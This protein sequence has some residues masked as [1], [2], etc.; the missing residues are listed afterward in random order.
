MN[1]RKL[2]NLAVLA[3]VVLSV[4]SCEKPY[5]GNHLVNETSPYLLQHAFNPVDWF[6]WGQEALNKA[7]EE[8]KL[9]VISVG[10]ASCH[11]CHVMEEESFEDSLVS[12]VMNESFISIKV[13]KE[14]RPDIDGIYMDACQLIR[15][16]SCGW[17]LNVIALPD[18]RPVFAGTYFEKEQWIQILETYK[19]RMEEE[20]DDL[21]DFANDLKREIV[22][23]DVI[24]DF[25]IDSPVKDTLLVSYAEQLKS[26]MDNLHGGRQG[27]I[28]FPNPT[29]LELL[30]SYA[31]LY[32]DQEAFDLVELT[33][34]KMAYGGIYD[35]IGGGFSRYSTDRI[36]KIPHFEKMLYDN[37]QLISVYSKAYRSFKNEEFKRVVFETIDF[38][39][40]ELSVPKG[41]YFSSLDADSDGEEGRYYV[42]KE[43]EINGLLS[44]DKMLNI[45]KSYYQI[46]GNGQWEYDQNVLFPQRSIE[47][48]AREFNLG[49]S[50]SET[51]LKEAKKVVAEAR[52]LRNKP[53]LDDKTLV[54]W[55]ALMID[56]LSE[57][58][59]SFGD[60][61][62]LER[63]IEVADFILTNMKAEDGRLYR[64]YKG[65]TASINAFLDDYANLAKAFINL[66]TVS[67]DERWLTEA[68]LLVDYV[69]LHFKDESSQIYYYTSD[70]DDALMTRKKEIIDGVIP[71]SNSTLARVIS[72]LGVLQDNKEYKKQSMS[73]LQTIVNRPNF[74]EYISFNSNWGMLYLE[75]I[76]KV[77][78]VVVMG[79]DS[80][81]NRAQLMSIYAPNV[82]F[83]GS[84]SQS[85]L[86]LLEGKYVEG[87]NYIYVCKSS[88][89][90]FPVETVDEA[91]ILL[92]KEFNQD[93]NL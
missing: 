73:M 46:G 38:C 75:K 25:S 66:Y 60:K 74:K 12:E 51:A 78:E 81:A 86:P 16:K 67:F 9:I 2:Q 33:L 76:R 93:I 56:G 59:R 37:A 32:E 48:F 52:V 42:W 35:H 34:E 84:D 44:D 7:E 57:A 83:M 87:A 61:K 91:V 31:H 39:D 88:M 6:P 21:E 14:E 68:Q 13:D 53:A 70:E 55:N 41:P 65:T 90:K 85:E 3:L 15:N 5:T 64:N 54:S 50:E 40:N 79:P 10:F 62:H 69:N 82:Y 11:W 92:E 72:D 1:L 8:D 45:F 19:Y 18:G 26:T 17:P 24:P 58:Y 30:L 23:K 43:E 49:I 89:C 80:D 77:Y 36:W 63:A 22:R 20:R 47:S 27:G 71:S 29:N 28:K 4:F